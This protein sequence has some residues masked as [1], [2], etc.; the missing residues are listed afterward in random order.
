MPARNHTP[1]FRFLVLFITGI[2]TSVY[3]PV[4]SLFSALAFCISVLIL[5]YALGL[6]KRMLRYKNRWIPGLTG[7]MVAFF[8]G[9]LITI[10]HAEKETPYH[11][12]KQKVAT[13]FIALVDEPL[14][15]KE[16]SRRTFIRICFLKVG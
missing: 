2:L 9:Y 1:L 4:L 7:L 3:V 15:E 5:F 6:S 10:L 16:K 13:D 8:S 11:F 14:I 12:R